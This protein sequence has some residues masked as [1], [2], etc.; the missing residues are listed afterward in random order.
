MGSFRVFQPAYKRVSEFFIAPALAFP[1]ITQYPTL[2]QYLYLRTYQPLVSIHHQL[3]K[4]K[5]L[6]VAATALF[7][8][9]TGIT[10][11][12]MNSPM[13]FPESPSIYPGGQESHLPVNANGGY[14][15]ASTWKPSLDRNGALRMPDEA[16]F[17]KQVRT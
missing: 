14:F 7:A 1:L 11:D 10:F 8:Q 13:F 6:S 15:Q 4:M 16:D 3:L 9:Q 5:P 12:G 2:V 17:Q